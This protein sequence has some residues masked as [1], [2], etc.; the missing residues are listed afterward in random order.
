MHVTETI[1][2]VVVISG[3]LNLVLDDSEVPLRPGDCLVQ[4]GT[5]HA[6]RNTGTGPCRLAAILIDA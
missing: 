6:W 1:D 4:R 3:E 5:S 2:Y